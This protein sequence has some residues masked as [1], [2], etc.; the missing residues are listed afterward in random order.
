MNYN[1][2][3]KQL[4]KY[5]TMSLDAERAE[6]AIQ[7][8]TRLMEEKKLYL[9]PDL[10]LKDLARELH[11]H[12]NHLSWILN[13]KFNLGYNDFINEFRIRDAM[14]ILSDPSQ[15]EKTILQVM[16]QTGFYS[17]SV[18]NTAFKKFSGKTPSVYR[19]EQLAEAGRQ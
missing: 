13:E 9:N 18:F 11:I 1:K 2:R 17:K 7:K 3:K 15:K 6:Q 19:R 8:V 5:K 16:Y 14:N 12:Y 10:T 4:N